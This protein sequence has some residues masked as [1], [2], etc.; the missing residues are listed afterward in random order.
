MRYFNS[1][2]LIWSGLLYILRLCPTTRWATAVR[3]PHTT[4]YGPCSPKLGKSPHMNPTQPKINTVVFLENAYRTKNFYS[5]CQITL[6]Q[7]S[8]FITGKDW[9][10][11]LTTEGILI[12]NSPTETYSRYWWDACTAP[13]G[14]HS[15]SFFSNHMGQA[16]NSIH[17]KWWKPGILPLVWE[18]T[19]KQKKRLQDPWRQH[20]KLPLTEYVQR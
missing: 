12:V 14:R 3:N 7:T 10:R 20:H 18:V 4:S 1:N 8:P 11:H 16:L 2:N 9:N 13:F 17:H 6:E 15:D 19:D 5:N